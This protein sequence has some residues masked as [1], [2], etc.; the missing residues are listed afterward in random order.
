MSTINQPSRL[1]LT[2]KSKVLNYEWKYMLCLVSNDRMGVGRALNEAC[3]ISF[4]SMT[5]SCAQ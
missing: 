2:R 3:Q 4:R 1:S 5:V